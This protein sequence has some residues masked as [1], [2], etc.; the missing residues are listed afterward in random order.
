MGIALKT[1]TFV[2]NLPNIEEK[3]NGLLNFSINGVQTGITVPTGQYSLAELQAVIKVLFEANAV[4]IAAGAT[5]ETAITQ[6]GKLAATVTG[7]TAE[8]RGSDFRSE[9]VL[10]PYLGNTADSGVIPAAVAYEFQTVPDLV[11]LKHATIHVATKSPHTVLNHTPNSARSV[12]SLGVIPITVPF[13]RIQTFEQPDVS[14]AVLMFSYP[15]DMSQVEFNVRREDGQRLSG[16]ENSLMI[17]L[18]VY[19]E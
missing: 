15:E 19:F 9:G 7:A 6:T 4:V 11:G 2:N 17:E 8:W 13:G 12:N 14:D 1:A 16:Q 3:T 18:I 10:N 5:L